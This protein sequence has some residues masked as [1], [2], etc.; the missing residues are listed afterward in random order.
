MLLPNPSADRSPQPSI[1]DVFNQ[2]ERSFLET[3]AAAERDFVISLDQARANAAG[4]AQAELAEVERSFRAA[5]DV[6]LREFYDSLE[7]AWSVENGGT[8]EPRDDGPSSWR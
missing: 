7:W 1:R 6:S 2:A 5:A 8:G 4:E 3:R